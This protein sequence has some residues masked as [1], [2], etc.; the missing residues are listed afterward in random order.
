MMDTI[1]QAQ[2]F[3]AVMHG[4]AALLALAAT[5]LISSAMRLNKGAKANRAWLLVAIG[6]ILVFLAEGNKFLGV[7]NLPSFDK[8]DEV[9]MF[10]GML[11]MLLGILHW[12][13]LL[14]GM[15]K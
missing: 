7:M 3:L 6:L 4:G 8:Y 10:F 11:F 2:W 13:G 5:L 15:L 1:L 9:K 14:K 12:R